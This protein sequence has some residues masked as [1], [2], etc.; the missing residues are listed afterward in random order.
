MSVNIVAIFGDTRF[1]INRGA[2]GIANHSRSSDS[3]RQCRYK[4]STVVNMLSSSSC[5]TFVSLDNLISTADNFKSAPAEEIKQDLFLKFMNKLAIWD[6]YGV[7][8][9]AWLALSDLDKIEK[10]NRYYFDMKSRSS[11]GKNCFILFVLV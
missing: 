7:S 5:Y 10:I 4:L 6:Y 8:R 11:S 9:D 1:S 2:P 3:K